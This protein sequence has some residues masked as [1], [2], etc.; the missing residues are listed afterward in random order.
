M[1]L[2]SFVQTNFLGG[3]ISQSAQGRMDLPAYKISLNVCL[4]AIPVEPG[5]WMR[6][7]G[8]RHVAPTRGGAQGKAIPF[9]FAQ[10]YPYV[11]VFTDGFLRFTT[12]PSL[13]MTNDAQAVTAISSAN[14]AEVTTTTAHGWSTGN[15]V[16]FDTLG[17]NNPLLQNRQFTITV[18]APTKFTLADSITG[19]AIDGATLGTFVSGN[20]N[21]IL[22][23]ATG[24]TS[25]SWATLRSVQAEERTVL[26]NG[27]RPQI[28]EV[29]TDPTPTQ[30][31]TFTYSQADF[32]DGPYLDPIPG[33][34]VTS[35]A[36]NG[37]VSLTFAYSEYD[38]SKAYRVGDFVSRLGVGYRSLTSPNQGNTPGSSPANWVAVNGGAAINNGT[39]FVASDIGRLVRLF[40]EPAL[41]SA[42]SSYANGNT[43]A[44]FDSNGGYSY[45]RA[46]GAIAA[47]VPPGGSSNWV[48]DPNIANWTWAQIT[49]V[50]GL[51][52]V[53]PVSAIGS[54]GLTGGGGL[55]AA[56]DGNTSKAAASSALFT[57][58]IPTAPVWAINTYAAGSIVQYGSTVYT[59]QMRIVDY[60]A[61]ASWGPGIGYAAGQTVQDSGFEYVAGVNGPDQSTSPGNN[62]AEWQ[63]T[64]A[65]SNVAPPF[66]T[67]W[68]VSSVL[69]S[70]TYDLYIGQH[71]TVATTIE[72]ATIYPSSD[73]G[74][75][76]SPSSG[77]LG[78]RLRASNTAPASPSDGTLLGSTAF[79]SNT[80]SSITI[81]SNDSVSA[82]N[83]V[84]FEVI[85]S[86]PQPLPDDGS[87]AYG[88]RIAVSQAQFF[89][90]NVS[91]G[92]VVT[93]QIRGDALANNQVIRTWRLGVYS[94]TTGWPT[95]GAYHEGRLWLG[96]VVGNRFDACVSN[97]IS[98]SAINFAPTGPSGIVAAN[99]AISYTCTGKDVNQLLW[100]EP[101]Q[102]GILFGTKAG[103][104]LISAPSQGPLAPANVKAVRVTNIGC[105]DIEP[106]RTEHTLVFVQ[107][108]GR[109]IMEYFAD[110]FSGK[111]SAPNLSERAKHVTV[112]GLEEIAYQQE[113]APVIWARRGDGSLVGAT[114]RRNSLTTAQG[115]DVI[116]WHRHR[117]GSGRTVESLCVGPSASGTLDTLTMI[118]ND[119]NTG[120]RHIELMTDLLDEDF[121]LIDCWFLDNAIVP[122][123][124]EVDV[125][126]S[127]DAPYGSLIVN[128][129]SAHEGQ[130]VT[131][132]LAGLDCGEFEVEGGAITVPFGD[133][134][135]GGTGSG[136]FT[137]ALVESFATLPAVV[138]F[139][140]T[141][142][143]QL[144]RPATPADTGTRSGPGFGKTRRQHKAA[145]QLYGCV[146]GSISFGTDFNRLDPAK[147]WQANDTPYTV[148]QL[149]SGIWR[150]E[151]DSKYDYDGNLAWRIS[152]PLPAFVI[153]V[154]G[155]DAG[156]D[157]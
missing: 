84:W 9:A 151:V 21:R 145:A 66:T 35:S 99:N 37:V 129:L 83:Y 19:A 45:W 157:V 71:Y 6:R 73:L 103:E 55:A 136:L 91:N 4:N 62:P 49:E 39:G 131:A 139:T 149:W 133:G 90:P 152:R 36:L 1:P 150:D 88:V 114:Y 124:T 27:S 107:K 65:I 146:N 22:E 75:E 64:N 112:S 43:V 87:H 80:V 121:L 98:G 143:G 54:G 144:L 10:N 26:L 79:I 41:Y 68:A 113:L 67:L 94:D 140:Y 18:T 102:Q 14:P 52:L 15:A 128:G 117:L 42:S 77:V 137:R 120:I 115:P 69:T 46:I 53:P 85:V 95:C 127:D 16:A 44:F 148:Q 8:T 134:V 33:S 105:A 57:T 118:T 156:Q 111:F 96:G 3:E 59:A 126:T 23:I 109:K 153:A 81:T 30:F 86:Y 72:S 122:S 2:A 97:G 119:P 154:G 155:F 51:G 20:V 17:T 47:G 104:W 92:S 7:P 24:Y 60:S 106:K 142:D 125:T 38:S 5:V 32:I 28:L 78:F 56:F 48:L 100:M 34:V 31:A 138:G 141:S 110:V 61:A 29:E 101:D 123:S 58:S 82:W 25:G 50:S 63:R 93:A 11:M 130:T 89:S 13:A 70:P 132:F 147:L 108:F 12:G 135:S 116:G 74:F 76:N 40:S